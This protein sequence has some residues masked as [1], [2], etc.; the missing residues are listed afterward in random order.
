MIIS[1]VLALALLQPAALVDRTVAIVDGRAITLS[2][3]RVAVELGL[4]EGTSADA[5]VVDRLIDRELMLRETDRY[6]PPD[7]A[8]QAIEA[9]LDEARQ[10][11]GGEAALE[12]VLEAGGFSRM[13]LRGW[14]R[15]DLRIAA[16]LEQRFV[17]DDRRADLIADW[18]ADLRRRTTITVIGQE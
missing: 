11:A 14:I 7:P 9:R 18:V 17:V 8:P 15:D 10:Q 13:R 1:L 6:T 5:A 2:D 16:Y 4:V 12:R 3:A